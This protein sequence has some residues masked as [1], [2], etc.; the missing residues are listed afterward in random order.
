MIDDNLEEVS[1][2]INHALVGWKAIEMICTNVDRL[3][4]A[5]SQTATA[6]SLI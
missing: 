4:I 3:S 5:N 2:A 6:H 1:A